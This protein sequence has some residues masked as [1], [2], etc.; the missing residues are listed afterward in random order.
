MAP[1][2]TARSAPRRGRHD[3]LVSPI[4]LGLAGAWCLVLLAGAATVPVYSVIHDGPGGSVST[5]AT[6]IEVNGSS[7]YIPVALPLVPVVVV[8]TALW[9][10]RRGRRS[11]AGPVAWT[12]VG[13][14]GAFAVVSGFSIGLFVVPVVVLLTVACATTVTRD[15]GV[16]H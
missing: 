7:A 3:G 6:L 13:V 1:T 5:S 16:S 8:G 14:L 12:I 2:Q 9:V 15:N 11:G 10:R 4:A